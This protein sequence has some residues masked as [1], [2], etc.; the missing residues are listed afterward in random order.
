MHGPPGGFRFRGVGRVWTEY[1]RLAVLVDDQRNMGYGPLG[2]T[3]SAMSYYDSSVSGPLDTRLREPVAKGVVQASKPIVPFVLV[4]LLCV[5]ISVLTVIGVAGLRFAHARTVF[6]IPTLLL[7]S[8]VVLRVAHLGVAEAVFDPAV[9][10]SCG[11]LLFYS[12][13]ALVHPENGRSLY[14]SA[15]YV[16]LWGAA[17]TAAVVM[18]LAGYGTSPDRTSS[19]ILQGPVKSR[20]NPR[21]LWGWLV[22]VTV[23]FFVVM[24]F[25]CH[26]RGIS[27]TVFVLRSAYTG[28]ATVEYRAASGFELW[29][30]RLTGIL[31][32]AV[33]IISGAYLSIPRTAKWRRTMVWAIVISCNLY[34]VA[35]GSRFRFVY[36][37]GGA[38]LVW[39]ALSSQLG[40]LNTRAIRTR[41]AL[42]FIVIATIGFLMVFIRHLGLTEYLR[43]GRRAPAG[44]TGF[45]ERGV[46]QMPR[47]PMVVD[48]VPQRRPHTLGLTFISPLCTFVP[49]SVWPQKPSDASLYLEGFTALEWANASFG[50]LGEAYLNFGI[51]G[52]FGGMW[53]FGSSARIWR[54]FFLRHRGNVTLT[55]I[56]AA[57][58]PVWF[59][60]VRGGFHSM[61]GVMLYA[62]L[63]VTVAVK[64]SLTTRRHRQSA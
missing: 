18:F 32:I 6:M 57:S 24:L 36:G 34:L 1:G 40:E 29:A 49:R 43:G 48:A 62:L 58:I 54:R 23:I 13:G 50:L 60:V 33:S 30:R 19:N 59:F 64:G 11:F 38:L 47:L 3:V 22:L 26:S 2:E 52:V 56:H 55:C 5:I 17:Y 31:P 10:A 42:G 61:V 37:C 8:F 4:V 15:E 27:L 28:E 41:L 25:V 63:T 53:V 12:T 35:V 20:L 46:D 51:L 16:N 14:G 39:L 45:I 44:I 7:L 21:K 9:A